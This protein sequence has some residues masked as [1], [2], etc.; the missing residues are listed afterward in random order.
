MGI[1]IVEISMKHSD[2]VVFILEDAKG[3]IIYEKDGYMP[4]VGM[5][6]DSDTTDLK[7]DNE[8]GK[9][10]GWKPITKEDLKSLEEAEENDE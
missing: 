2:L 8:T 10:I 1:K 4:H 5:F 7:I 9:I 6:N 3:D